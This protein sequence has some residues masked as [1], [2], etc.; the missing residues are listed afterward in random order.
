ML[1]LRAA[2]RESVYVERRMEASL[3]AEV[4][5]AAERIDLLTRDIYDSLLVSSGVFRD[6]TSGEEAATRWRTSDAMVNVPFML[7]F[8][9]LDVFGNAE[10]SARFR[11]AFGEFLVGRG[12]IPTYDL[13][14]RIYLASASMEAPGAVMD[15]TASSSVRK[16]GIGR[17]MM[18]SRMIADPETD[19]AVFRQAED[20]G[21]ETYARNVAPQ[22]KLSQKYEME[23]AATM[24][25]EIAVPAQAQPAPAAARTAET[26]EAPA[27][28]RI[29]SRSH[30]FDELY[31]AYNHGWLPYITGEGLEILFWQTIPNDGR[32][33]GCTLRVDIL[34]D[35]IADA[36]PQI[37]SDARV[38]TVLDESG[39][40]IVKPAL[41]SPEPDWMRPFVAREISATLPRWEVGAWLVDPGSLASRADYTRTLIWIQVAILASV[42]IVGSVV[43][44][45]MLSYEMRVASQKTTFVANVSHELKT[46]LT[47]IRLFAELLLSG[48]QESEERRREY[49]RTMMSEADRLSHLVS[50]VLTFSR[51]GGEYGMKSISLSEVARDTLSQLEPHLSRQGY[52]VSYSGDDALPI[53]GNRE[54]LKQVIMN[55]LSNAEKYSDDAREISLD[56]AA[57]DGF[58]V[59]DVLDRGRGVDPGIAGKI[60]Q[61]FFRADDSLTS[62]KSGTGLGLSIARDIARR[63]GGDVR[64]R[65]R[66]G[67]GSVFS[68]TLPLADR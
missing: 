57:R 14:T 10:D 5:L 39:T 36:I 6:G 48:K 41:E 58:A 63:H 43:V 4:G 35:R 23:P 3:M 16:T 61:E 8:E 19:E 2:E 27:R 66:E 46:P 50:N 12:R 53:R 29:V 20:E 38:L 11:E 32:V 28:S 1:A 55:L 49:L 65:P 47:S 24:A 60:F 22:S 56:C 62:P 34:K 64:Y 7:D 31:T 51:H 45:R 26:P 44:I 17:Q 40:P 25:A 9:R 67:G 52:A 15:D 18:E 42:I 59:V 33:V 30:S 13:V 37:L 21:F 54:A 68:L